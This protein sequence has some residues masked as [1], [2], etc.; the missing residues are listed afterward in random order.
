RHRRHTPLER[1]DQRRLSMTAPGITARFI[2]HAIASR[3]LVFLLCALLL[4]LGIYSFRALP[5]EAYPN[6][7][8]LNI[9]IITQ[10][11]GRSTLE[12][13][14]QLTI[15]IETAVAGVPDVGSIRSV[16]LFGLSVVT[17]NFR[18]GADD[19]RSRQNTQMY[20]GQ[21]TLPTGVTATISPDADATGEI[22]RYRIESQNPALDITDLKSLQ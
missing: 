4:S 15:P 8:P 9:Q 2:D 10:G 3:G 6:I 16:S 19:F 5:I 11:A 12:I 7:A 22:M 20:L 1:D 18:E 21:A 14:R 13:E 17:I